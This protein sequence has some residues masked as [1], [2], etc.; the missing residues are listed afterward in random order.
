MDE[1]GLTK[2]MKESNDCDD[3]SV[4]IR[5]ISN[6]ISYVQLMDSMHAH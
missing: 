6:I 1:L 3:E 4:Y 5:T 2:S